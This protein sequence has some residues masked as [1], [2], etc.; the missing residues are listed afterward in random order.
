MV[1]RMSR[2]AVRALCLAVALSLTVAAA[3]GPASAAAVDKERSEKY[4]QDAQNYLK[5]KDPNAAIIQ[6]KNALKSD[7]GNIAARRMLGRLYL[8]LGNGVYAEKEL[9]TAIQ[10]GAPFGEIAPDLARAYLLQGKFDA[11]IK[12]ITLDKVAPDQKYQALIERGQA[13]LSLKQIDDAEKAFHAAHDLNAKEPGPL[14]GLAQALIN[15]GKAKEAEAE[16]D[17]ALALAPDDVGALTMKGELRR[18]VGDR[19]G[20]IAY[21]GKALAKRPTN[22]LALLGRAAA[23]IDMNKDADAEK[24]LKQV[25]TLVPKHPMALYLQA[26]SLAKKRDY[27]GAREKLQDAGAALDE[28]MPS[29]FLKGAVA[30]A[31]NEQEQAIKNLVLYLDR[32]PGNLRARELLAATYMRARQ[33]AKVL[34]VLQPSLKPIEDAYALSEKRLE[35][36]KDPKADPTALEAEQKR[37]NSIGVEY[38]RFMSLMGT[39]YMQL[40]K[41]NEGTSYFTKAS[42]AAPDAASIR[43]QLA[44]SHLAQGNADEATG[45]LKMALDIDKDSNRAGILLALV[46]LRKAQYDDALV[47]ARKLKDMKS[48]AGNPLPDNLMG[49]AYLGKKDKAKATEMF[50]AALKVKPDFAPARMNLAQLAMIDGKLD[51]ARRQYQAILKDNDKS[52]DAMTALAN[53][54]NR[55]NKP[56]EVAKWLK[57]ASDANPKAIAP[58]LRLIAFYDSRRNFAQALT[59]ARQLNIDVPNDPRVL[60]VLGRAELA[61]GN[62]DRAMSTLRQLSE[63]V[64]K[65]GRALVLLAGAQMAA[66]QNDTARGTLRKAIAVD[67]NYTPAHAALVQLEVGEKHFDAA[68]KIADDLRDARPKSPVGLLMRGDILLAQDKADQ[69]IAA[70]EAGMKRAESTVLILRL[71]N[72]ERK[73]KKTDAA[74]ATIENWL[75]K[76]EDDNA[77]R[78]VLASA[79]LTDGRYDKAIEQSELLLAK[80]KNNAVVLNNL[81]WLY[82]KTGDKRAKEFAERAYEAAPK[83]AAIMDTLGWILVQNG[84]ADRGAEIL[85]QAS[86]AAPNAGD[87]L[88]HRAAALERTGHRA[89]ARK[90]LER[91]LASAD[92]LQGFST[93]KDAEALLDQ[94]KSGG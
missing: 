71:Y 80:V 42:E 65:S 63:Q 2:R 62:Q 94:L 55:E 47:S 79:Y 41:V 18:I 89:E 81:A 44:L 10:R 54:A 11:V 50:E 1:K 28:H 40:G 15:R 51:D 92:K 38:A 60:E 88:Y 68:L 84:E 83:S 17:R 33:P 36:A 30:Y 32:V 14:V 86:E 67:P 90:E 70:Y 27:A 57:M 82:Q 45:D 13:Y 52:V 35:E 24:D 23:Q 31:L 25:L 78:N 69:A 61:A 6:L 91:L 9:K 72:A 53:L 74:Y 20:A 93:R 12:E 66:K 37:H 26:L 3:P 43:T 59:V 76:H 8:D 46:Q 21:F 87:I 39:A 75:A 48:M 49:A 5:K 16:A 64:P 19:D 7:P 58:Q 56:D 85:K 29:I 22:V 77:V 73:A 4:L 34:D